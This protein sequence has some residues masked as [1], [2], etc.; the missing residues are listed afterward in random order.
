MLKLDHLGP[1]ASI[2]SVIVC[3]A[4]AEARQDGRRQI[5]ALRRPDDVWSR[6]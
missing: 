6:A 1:Q 5:L 2:P 4:A 3:S